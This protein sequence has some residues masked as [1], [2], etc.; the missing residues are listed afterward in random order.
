MWLVVTVVPCQWGVRRGL[1]RLRCQNTQVR[2]TFREV[3]ADPERRRGSLVVAEDRPVSFHDALQQLLVAAGSPTQ[4]LMGSWV[5]VSNKTVSD[6]FT[7]KV[8]E[9]RLPGRLDKLIQLLEDRAVQVPGHQRRSVQEWRRLRFPQDGKPL[10]RRRNPA[11]IVPEPAPAVTLPMPR[12]SGVPARTAQFIGREDEL[13]QLRAAL[14]SGHAT[15][16]TQ[17]VHGLGGVGKTATVTEFC[18]RHRADFDVVRWVPAHSADAALEN[19]RSFAELLGISHTDLTL[20]DVVPL[21]CQ[22]LTERAKRVLLVF[23]NVDQPGWLEH[24]LPAGNSIAIIITSRYQRWNL[25]GMRTVALGTL[26]LDDSVELLVQAS[27]NDDR[28]GA[29]SLAS[30]L[31]GLSLALRQAAVYCQRQRI[32]FSAYERLLHTN[33]AELYARNPAR[34]Q[35]GI[36]ADADFTIRAVLETSLAAATEEG[37]RAAEILRISAYLPAT[38]IRTELFLPPVATDEELLA[39]GDEMVIRESL[40]ALESFALIEPAETSDDGMTAFNVHRVIQ[41][42]CRATAREQQEYS[43]TAVRLVRRGGFGREYVISLDG[44]IVVCLERGSGR[45]LMS[46]TRRPGVSVELLMPYHAQDVPTALGIDQEEVWA[47]FADHVVTWHVGATPT[48]DADGPV[49]GTSTAAPACYPAEPSDIRLADPPASFA[50]SSEDGHISHTVTLPDGGKVSLLWEYEYFR[51][52][53]DGRPDVFLDPGWYSRRTL[54]APPIVD[55]SGEHLVLS[56]YTTKHVDHG[57]L[58]VTTLSALLGAQPDETVEAR[59]LHPNGAPDFEDEAEDERS[60]AA[61]TDMR[62]SPAGECVMLI[63]RTSIHC[64]SWPEFELRWRITRPELCV[65]VRSTSLGRAVTRARALRQSEIDRLVLDDGAIVDVRS[66]DLRTRHVGIAESVLALS[67]ADGSLLT[68]TGITRPDL[69][70][71]T[72][73]A[74]PITIASAAGLMDGSFLCLDPEGVLIWLA[75]DGTTESTFNTKR[76][77]AR[78]LAAHPYG[79][80]LALTDDARVVTLYTVEADAVRLIA[81]WDPHRPTP[82]GA[83][84][85][86]R[87]DLRRMRAD[88]GMTA[89]AFV[90]PNELVTGWS[91]GQIRFPEWYLLGGDVAVTSLAYEADTVVT[92]FANGTVRA[93]A[94][95]QTYRGKLFSGAVTHVLPRIGQRRFTAISA[96]GDVA[97]VTWH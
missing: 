55:P 56:M 62:F 6:W 5:G 44:E 77:G 29:E 85:Q 9:S 47:Q 90:S 88:F 66:D 4:T 82:L 15:A 34:L 40:A 86:M 83:L 95:R 19:L 52:V 8:T 69:T 64:W 54:E 75:A 74:P 10:A 93:W 59:L 48:G 89:A 61:V 33:A 35:R 72:P 43:E 67:P 12:F 58:A 25:H 14:E 1:S 38:N 28:A 21:V 23:D 36:G 53:R 94:S 46:R 97:T 17:V 92:G 32:S 73:I 39:F 91:N 80:A 45:L 30:H 2:G 41:H 71:R 81:K 7:G 42:L 96:D 79:R 22:I 31:G 63:D 3:R 20:A 78:I 27:G 16:V 65:T 37:S 11:P 87:A 76:P 18:H 60:W 84:R 26:S 50:T 13:G 57:W 49:V 70:G 51:L 24:L 68:A